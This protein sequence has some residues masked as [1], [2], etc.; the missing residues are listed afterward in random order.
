[1]SDLKDFKLLRKFVFVQFL[2]IWTDPPGKRNSGCNAS[3]ESL[4]IALWP[5]EIIYLT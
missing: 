3:I 1:L 5:E 2:N 4:I